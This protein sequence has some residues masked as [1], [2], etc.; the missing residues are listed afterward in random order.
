MPLQHTTKPLRLMVVDDNVD[1][2][3]MMS[4]LLNAA[5]HQ[6]LIEHSSKSALERAKDEMPD[7]FL[8]DIGLPEIDGNELAERIR[9]QPENSGA[10]LIAVT[11]YGQSIDRQRSLHAGFDHHLVKPVDTTQ[12]KEILD[13]INTRVKAAT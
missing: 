6:V 4:M 3:D 1:G 10:V 2:A 9:A 8:L 12:L 13:K 11:G 5:G 7:A